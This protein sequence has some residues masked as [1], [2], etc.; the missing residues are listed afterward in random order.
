MKKSFGDFRPEVTVDFDADENFGMDKYTFAEDVKRKAKELGVG[1]YQR[2]KL[3]EDHEGIFPGVRAGEAFDGQLPTVIRKLDLDQLSALYSL[4]SNWYGY[5]TTQ[6]MLAAAERSEAIRKKEFML[7][8]LKVFYRNP[9]RGTPKPP[10]TA[11]SDMA[12]TDRRFIEVSAAYE[13]INAFYDVLDAMR[14]VADQDMKVISREVTIQQEKIR[15]ELLGQGFGRRGKDDDFDSAVGGEGHGTPPNQ[16]T[17]RERVLRS[18]AG[19]E[20]DR[21]KANRVQTRARRR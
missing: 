18:E 11:V 12:K 1:Y 8:H 16:T 9:P 17:Q 13:Q 6:T 19:R 15:K 20:D 10:E 3:A 2:P 14:K 4:Y 7:N 5:L 21:P